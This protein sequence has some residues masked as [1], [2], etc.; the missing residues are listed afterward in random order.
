MPRPLWLTSSAGGAGD[1][2]R[3]ARC[4]T[5]ASSAKSPIT[6][7]NSSSISDSCV[8]TCATNNLSPLVSSTLA[9]ETPSALLPPQ[10]DMCCHIRKLVHSCFA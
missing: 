3:R 1:S 9:Q 6:V 4:P 7:P 8:T 5:S 10:Y 2:R